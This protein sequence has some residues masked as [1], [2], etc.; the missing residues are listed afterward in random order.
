M[1]K[2]EKKID[3]RIIKTKEKL[4]SALIELM[5]QKPINEIRISELCDACDISR[6]TFY[7]NFN[8]IEEVLEYYILKFAHPIEEMAIQNLRTRAYSFEEIFASVTGPIVDSLSRNDN[9]PYLIL[10][11]NNPKDFTELLYNLFYTSVTGMLEE[12]KKYYT[13]DIP[14]DIFVQHTVG[15]LTALFLYY[16]QN[17]NKYSMDDFKKYLAITILHKY[18][19]TLKDN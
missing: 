15:S 7:N 16:L 4:S 8:K 11:H 9:F 5:K 3:R 19:I 6:A 12:C 13:I 10:Q 1:K 2:N 14:A 17:R 18:H